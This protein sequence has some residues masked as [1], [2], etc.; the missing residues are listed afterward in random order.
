MGKELIQ[1]ELDLI[2]VELGMELVQEME[3]EL[4]VVGPGLKAR[5]APLDSE[6]MLEVGKVGKAKKALEK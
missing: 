6:V 2:G 3:K 5:L 1:V 4:V